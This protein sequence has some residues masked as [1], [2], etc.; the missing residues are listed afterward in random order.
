MPSSSS[1]VVIT[2]VPTAA[3]EDELLRMCSSFGD[4]VSMRRIDR[5]PAALPSVG[6]AAGGADAAAGCAISFRVE[7]E[8]EEDAAAC[9]DNMNGMLV[10]ERCLLAEV[11]RSSR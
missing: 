11:I 7:F 5:S 4:V 6:A 2:N 8:A 3:S 1:A 10:K 9:A